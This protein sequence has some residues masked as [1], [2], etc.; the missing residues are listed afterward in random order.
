MSFEFLSLRSLIGDLEV[1]KPHLSVIRAP[2]FLRLDWERSLS[3]GQ[4]KNDDRP[5]RGQMTLRFCQGT[6][7]CLVGVR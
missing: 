6:R 5:R 1:L 3:R 2:C 7:S 4:R